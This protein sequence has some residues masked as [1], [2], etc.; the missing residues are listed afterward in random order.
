M[1]RAPDGRRKKYLGEC[2]KPNYKNVQRHR[3]R[4]IQVSCS[5]IPGVPGCDV[6]MQ[7]VAN[8]FKPRCWSWFAS[9]RFISYALLGTNGHYTGSLKC[10]L[11]GSSRLTSCFQ[12]GQSL[13][14]SPKQREIMKE[15]RV[16][17]PSS[18]ESQAV[19]KSCVLHLQPAVVMG[20]A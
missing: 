7:W 10:W 13:S 3:W 2:V 14:S 4:F 17:Q 15:S 9:F 8:L 12:R 19:F 6:N 16:L 20:I 5:S 1:W 18:C 11:G